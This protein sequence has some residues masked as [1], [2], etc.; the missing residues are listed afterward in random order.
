MKPFVLIYLIVVNIVGFY[1]MGEDKKRA[2]KR[3]WRIQE[4]TLWLVAA[5]GGAVGLTIGMYLFRHK[6]K[7]IAFKVGFPLLAITFLVLLFMRM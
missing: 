3:E 4:S 2:K 1:L 7:H 5:V 6:T